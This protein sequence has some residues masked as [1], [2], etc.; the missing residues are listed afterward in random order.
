MPMLA[1]PLKQEISSL[2][3]LIIDYA[4]ETGQIL[5][6]AGEDNLLLHREYDKWS[7]LL[8]DVLP[9]FDEPIFAETKK[10]LVKI[11]EK[12]PLSE[13]ERDILKRG[14]NFIRV[15][16]FLSKILGLDKK[17]TV[18]SV[19]DGTNILSIINGK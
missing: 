4:E 17:L 18:P 15:I 12:L 13:K 10:I 16:N 11:R 1:K 9:N 2:I 3:S 8:V 5:A 19:P 6:L 14:I 7:Y